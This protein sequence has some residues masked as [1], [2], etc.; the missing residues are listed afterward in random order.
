MHLHYL[1]QRRKVRR[2]YPNDLREFWQS[3]N[4]VAVPPNDFIPI[5]NAI[6]KHNSN[7][8]MMPHERI[9]QRLSSNALSKI[10]WARNSLVLV[11]LRIALHAQSFV[12]WLHHRMVSRICNSVFR[13]LL[14]M[15]L[16]FV[17]G[18]WSN[19]VLL[20]RRFADF[21]LTLWQCH[22]YAITNTITEDL[23]SYV[24]QYTKK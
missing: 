19:N 6:N 12:A 16:S 5:L 2:K 24:I 7:V 9:C 11:K 10:N 20:K 18:F 21:E 15:R 17:G 23:K 3:W 14:S 1:D 8:S 22:M 13:R 4:C